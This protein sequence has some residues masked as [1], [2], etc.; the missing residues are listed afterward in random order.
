M[1]KEIISTINI[2][3]DDRTQYNLAYLGFILSAIEKRDIDSLEK[4]YIKY[5]DDKVK[6]QKDHNNI[7]T[8]TSGVSFNLLNKELLRYELIH[9][10]QSRPNILSHI[11]DK[12][13]SV[14]RD[15]TTLK[16]MTETSDIKIN[17]KSI[18]FS[19]KYDL[20]WASLMIRSHTIFLYDREKY[21]TNFIIRN[22]ND[23]FVCAHC[24]S[25]TGKI[26]TK[27]NLPQ[28]PLEKCTCKY[29]CRCGIH[30]QEKVVL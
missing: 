2:P 29:G 23:N 19:S 28:L 21:N 1:L 24:R 27:E 25:M 14:L 9:I 6:V 15:L 8:V 16:L 11:S 3:F 13:Y 26:F 18:T 4:A 22:A 7:Q 20:K 10:Y 5:Y 17:F 12:E 30:I